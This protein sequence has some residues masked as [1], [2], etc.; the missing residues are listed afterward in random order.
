MPLL[1]LLL[2]LL[3]PAAGVWLPWSSV[4]DLP[5]S[6]YRSPHAGRLPQVSILIR[7][8]VSHFSAIAP[9]NHA[10]CSQHAAAMPVHGSTNCTAG[11]VALISTTA[12][13]P[14]VTA[15]AAAATGA[16]RCK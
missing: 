11:V 12:S 15:V 7:V 8:F 6:R 10:V 13:Y 14:G 16:Q 9:S 5:Y 4:H 1:S 2:L 3:L